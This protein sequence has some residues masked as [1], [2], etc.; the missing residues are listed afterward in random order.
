MQ[1]TQRLSTLLT[2]AVH[3]KIIYTFDGMQRLST[4]GVRGGGGGK[5]E[6]GGGLGVMTV[7]GPRWPR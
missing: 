2:N 5:P 4:P 1:G 7:G 3:A 6:G